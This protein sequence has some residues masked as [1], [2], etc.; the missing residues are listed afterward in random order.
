MQVQRMLFG[1]DTFENKAKT[2]RFYKVTLVE[3]VTEKQYEYGRRGNS[4]VDYFI[5][6]DL[7]QSLPDNYDGF[8]LADVDF[9]VTGGHAEIVDIRLVKPTTGK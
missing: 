6:R 8:P 3:P 5:N 1:K 2:G 7:Y 9:N 4:A